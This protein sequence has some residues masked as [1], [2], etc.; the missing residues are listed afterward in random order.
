MKRKVYIV[1]GVIG[2]LLVIGFVGKFIKDASS[3]GTSGNT[4]DEKPVIYLLRRTVRSQT[5]TDRSTI[6]S[7]GRAALN[8]STIF[9]RASAWRERIRQSSLRTPLSGSVLPAGRPMSLS[10]TGCPEWNRTSTIL[11]PS[12]AKHIQTT[13]A[14]PYSRNR[15]P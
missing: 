8:R 6:I 9:P 2:V 7:T 4:S 1:L 14:F 3:Y 11:S 10:Y 12:R 5:R 15:T 13:H